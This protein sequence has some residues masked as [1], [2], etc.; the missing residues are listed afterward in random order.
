M[1]S[2]WSQCPPSAG[3]KKK[4]NCLVSTAPFQTEY[5]LPENI[6]HRS[7]NDHKMAE[8]NNQVEQSEVE[9]F[10]NTGLAD[11]LEGIHDHSGKLRDSFPDL[12]F[13]FINVFLLFY[14]CSIQLRI[15]AQ[16]EP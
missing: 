8:G 12:I 1:T 14:T 16:Q 6:E 13:T 9:L 15:L 10:T 2:S 11:R 4:I 7:F 5:K 3:K